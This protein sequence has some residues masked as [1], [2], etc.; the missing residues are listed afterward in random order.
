MQNLLVNSQ[1]A[2]HI[3]LCVLLDASQV[4]VEL[5]VQLHGHRLIGDGRVGQSGILDNIEG[6]DHIQTH[7][8]KH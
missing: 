8:L 2:L 1:E 3:I 5:V 4:D 7:V 6:V